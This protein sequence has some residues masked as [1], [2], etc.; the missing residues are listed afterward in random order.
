MAMTKKDYEI[1]AD[2][3]SLTRY[4]SSNPEVAKALNTLTVR[5]ANLFDEAN[6]RFDVVKFLSACEYGKLPRSY[7]VIVPSAVYGATH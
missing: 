4:D 2:A 1:I 3:I 5:L 7:E 6:P